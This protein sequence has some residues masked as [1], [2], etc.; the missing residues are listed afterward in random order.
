MSVSK[1][2]KNNTDQQKWGQSCKCLLHQIWS[3]NSRSQLF[4]TTSYIRAH[5]CLKPDKFWKAIRRGPKTHFQ[6]LFKNYYLSKLFSI[7]YFS[8]QHRVRNTRFL[9][10]GND[11]VHSCIVVLPVVSKGWYRCQYFTWRQNCVKRVSNGVMKTRPSQQNKTNIFPRYNFE[12][13]NATS[14]TMQCKYF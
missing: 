8:K 4:C 2:S 9:S 14:H 11:P 13:S 3:S 1:A 7:K 12:R 10:W 5:N 6:S